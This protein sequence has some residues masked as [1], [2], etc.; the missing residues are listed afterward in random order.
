M[1]EGC[2]REAT[3]FYI[4]DDLNVQEAFGDVI[5]KEASAYGTHVLTS[6]CKGLHR[7]LWSILTAL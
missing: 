1:T 3:M 7:C 5:E 6:G 4:A 2:L